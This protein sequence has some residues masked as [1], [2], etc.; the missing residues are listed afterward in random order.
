MVLI[1]ASEN[2]PQSITPI[3][4]NEQYMVFMLTWTQCIKNVFF[5]LN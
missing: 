5:Y 2:L 4:Y 1:A 3:A